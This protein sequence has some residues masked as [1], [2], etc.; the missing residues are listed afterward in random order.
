MSRFATR[1]KTGNEYFSSLP[2]VLDLAK[3]IDADPWYV[4]PPTL[5]KEELKDL[6]TYVNSRAGEFNRIY[7]EYGNE[8]WGTGCG[9]DP[10]MGATVGFHLPKMADEAFEVMR[11]AGLS[12]KV[13]LIIGGQAAWVGRQSQIEANSD[14][15]D[16]TAIA[17]YYTMIEEGIT[18]RPTP[19]VANLLDYIYASPLI[20]NKANNKTNQS[21]K[22]ISQAG[23]EPAIY[24]INF[25]D[26]GSFPPIA[27]KNKILTGQAGGITL[28]LHMLHAMKESG[29][30][31]QTAFSFLQIY[32]RDTG[33]TM[34]RL[35]GIARDLDNI[36]A[37]RGTGL[38]LSVANKAVFGDLIGS[39]VVG[40]GSWSRTMVDE[41][42][43]SKKADH[44]IPYL[45][46]FAF[47]DGNRYGLIVFNVHQT[48]TIKSKLDLPGVG[49]AGT[50]YQLYHPDPLATNERSVNLTI[51]EVPVTIDEITEYEFPPHSITSFTWSE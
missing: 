6:T 32:F 10:F 20:R 19:T 37:Y 14:S 30:R 13:K 21:S 1:A 17:P 9:S 49:G 42:D 33:G 15:H 48:A 3:E 4:V 46:S 23:R 28:P 7:L 38:A 26:T 35:W 47:K 27:L 31:I 51:Q 44:V 39:N 22:I 41:F 12:S 8:M 24:E 5:T 36:Q 25:H 45:Q 34:T 11:D 2:E 43:R 16:I 29:I 18:N 50:R 40:G